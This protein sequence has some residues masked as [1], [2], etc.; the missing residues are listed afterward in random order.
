MTTYYQIILVINDKIYYCIVDENEPKTIYYHITLN[1][2]L[3]KIN[4]AITKL[5]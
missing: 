2:L 5:R 3:I 1:T 4:E